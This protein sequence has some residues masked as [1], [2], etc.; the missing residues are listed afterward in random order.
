M[1]S[2][3][4]LFTGKLL[5]P[6]MLNEMMTFI[7]ASGPGMETQTGLIRRYHHENYRSQW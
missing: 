3:K 2:F 5:S 6:V 7:P 4:N 1:C